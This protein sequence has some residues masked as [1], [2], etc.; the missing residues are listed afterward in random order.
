MTSEE[1]KV[2]LAMIEAE[3]EGVAEALARTRKRVE[4]LVCDLEEE[5][6]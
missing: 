6:E 1:F 3:L 5:E 4:D 2:G